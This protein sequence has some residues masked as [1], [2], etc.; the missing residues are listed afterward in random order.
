MLKWHVR[1]RYFGTVLVIKREFIRIVM[2]DLRVAV[3][4]MRF[5]HG[6]SK[7]LENLLFFF[8]GCRRSL[9]F[10][11]FKVLLLKAFAWTMCTRACFPS[12][13]KR[14]YQTIKISIT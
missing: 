1:G 8:I 3:C 4:R 6:V 13:L 11:T 5:Y 7:P 14:K 2:A 12:V 9:K 10:H